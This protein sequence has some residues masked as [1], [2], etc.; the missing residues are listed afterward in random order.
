MVKIRILPEESTPTLL[1]GDQSLDDPP[2]C[3]HDDERGDDEYFVEHE[4]S[5]LP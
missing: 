5:P 3:H 4:T 1:A 2:E